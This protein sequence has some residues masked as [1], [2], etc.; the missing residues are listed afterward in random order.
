MKF[1]VIFTGGDSVKVWHNG[2]KTTQGFMGYPKTGSAG[3]TDSTEGSV[4]RQLVERAVNN[5][6]SDYTVEFTDL[7]LKDSSE[8]TDADRTTIADTINNSDADVFL[9]V[10]G[11]H[12]LKVTMDH[13]T[14]N[15]PEDFAKPVCGLSSNSPACTIQDINEEQ[16]ETSLNIEAAVEYLDDNS[17]MDTRSFATCTENAEVREHEMATA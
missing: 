16:N 8:I 13:L 10:H 17:P 12:T 3:T 5:K 6:D 15:L 14:K 9:L 11:G 7:F 4:I 2:T 1:G